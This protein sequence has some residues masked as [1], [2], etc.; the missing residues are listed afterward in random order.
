MLGEFFTDLNSPNAI[1]ICI[2]GWRENP[3][4]HLI[5]DN[6]DNTATYSA[7]GWKTNFVGPLIAVAI[8]VK[9]KVSRHIPLRLAN[10]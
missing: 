5:R 9:T 7:F 3:D 4:A 8:A 10:N 1:T 6:N 2:Q